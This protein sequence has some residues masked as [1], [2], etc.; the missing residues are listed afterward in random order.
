MNIIA[1]FLNTKSFVCIAAVAACAVLSSPV[2][3]KDHEVEVKISVSAAGLD[4]SQPAGA[5]E[6]Y[7]RLQKAATIVCGNGNRVDLQPLTDFASCY[8]TAVG[9]AVRSADRPH[10]TMVYL[11]THTLQD[12]AA[13]GINVPVLVA[14][15]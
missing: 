13:R 2:Q 14:A 15:K 1:P 5:R 7:G 4:L 12:A 6:L 8:E 3:A 10:L 11:R 9:D